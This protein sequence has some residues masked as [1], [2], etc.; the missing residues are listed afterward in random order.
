MEVQRVVGVR[1]RSQQLLTTKDQT[2]H[3]SRVGGVEG[4][5]RTQH[6]RT[7]LPLASTVSL[8]SVGSARRLT[9]LSEATVKSTMK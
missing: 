7:P 4:R 5:L 9:R 3:Q 6:P 1:V 8:D 2:Q